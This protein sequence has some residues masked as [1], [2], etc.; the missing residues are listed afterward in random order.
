[1]DHIVEKVYRRIVEATEEDLMKLDAQLIISTNYQISDILTTIR[2]FSGVVIVTPG[3]DSRKMGEL[4]EKSS[5]K[6]KILPPADL[7]SYV[8]ALREKINSVPG[9]LSFKM[10]PARDK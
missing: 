9:V 6:M 4:K 8:E 10:R 5:L 7:K 2:A 1:M 3:G